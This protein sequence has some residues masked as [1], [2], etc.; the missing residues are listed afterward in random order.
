M[1][2]R[3][4]PSAAEILDKLGPHLSA[5]AEPVT[6]DGQPRALRV[7]PWHEAQAVTRRVFRTVGRVAD[8]WLWSAACNPA[9]EIVALSNGHSVRVG[10]EWVKLRTWAGITD[11]EHDMLCLSFISDGSRRRRGDASAGLTVNKKPVLVRADV[12]RSMVEHEIAEKVES[13]R[14]H[15][16][17]GE[18]VRAWFV[19]QFGDVLETVERVLTPV[20]NAAPEPSARHMDSVVRVSDYD[21]SRFHGE[22]GGLDIR[23]HGHQVR[24]FADLL[25]R[26]ES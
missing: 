1:A 26:L 11:A 2:T 17:E 20:V 5:F 9:S 21:M 3:P 13:A 6:R 23:L 10:D 4:V 12:L 7:V 22:P 19:E 15:N 18:R 8:A 14:K 16:E 24:A 25:R